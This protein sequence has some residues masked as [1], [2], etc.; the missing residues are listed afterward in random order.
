[1]ET[2]A[3]PSPSEPAAARPAGSGL[4]RR[5]FAR[6]ALVALGLLLVL[7]F[8]QKTPKEQHVRIVLGDAASEVTGLELQ[9][10]ARDGDVARETRLVFPRG[11]APRVVSHEPKLPNGDYRLEI[12]IDARDGR[13]ATQR[14]VTLGGGSTQIDVTDVLLPDRPSRR[15]STEQK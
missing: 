13:R 15:T 10:V 12:E 4:R 5:P 14:Q 7:Y 9:Y 3:P 6:I 1:V 11:G 2:D 8:G